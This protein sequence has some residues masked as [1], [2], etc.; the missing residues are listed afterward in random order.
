MPA[1]V[2]PDCGAPPYDGVCAAAGTASSA[3]AANAAPIRPFI[4]RTIHFDASRCSIG[5][6]SAAQPELVDSAEQLRGNAIHT[7]CALAR[8]LV[9]AI[10]ARQQTDRQHAGTTC[11]KQIPDRIAD[12]VTLLRWNV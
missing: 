1:A 10:A 2:C 8:Q 11:C 9:L 5:S 4:F 7:V 3:A 12:H 6:P